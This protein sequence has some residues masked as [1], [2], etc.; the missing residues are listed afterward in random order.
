MDDG[1]R[2]GVGG[3]GP[4]EIQGLEIGGQKSVLPGGEKPLAMTFIFYILRISFFSS[5]IQLD[6]FRTSPLPAPGRGVPSLRG[7]VRE[8]AAYSLTFETIHQ[9]SRAY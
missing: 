6:Y 4:D 5:L 2:S 1:K 8:H 7:G 9:T 3:Q